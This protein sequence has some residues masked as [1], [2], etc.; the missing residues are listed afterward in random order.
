MG[1]EKK[2]K[3]KKEG[4]GEEKKR[5]NRMSER[6]PHVRVRILTEEELNHLLLIGD[7]CVMEH[8]RL[9][10]DEKERKWVRWGEGFVV[11]GR[12]RKGEVREKG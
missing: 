11:G 7:D 10:R 2:K 8:R 12:R 1:E 9:Q 4:E 5:E 3:R 6:I